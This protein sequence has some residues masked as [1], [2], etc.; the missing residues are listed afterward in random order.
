MGNRATLY[1][2]RIEI[3][4]VDRGIYEP[5]DVRT[6]LHPSETP[7]FLL[8]RVLAYVLNVPTSND[9]KIEFAPGGISDTDE[10]AIRMKSLDGRTTMWI[11]IGSPSTKKLHKG[12]KTADVVKVYAHKDPSA[13]VQEIKADGVHRASEIEVYLFSKDL[14]NG[15]EGAIER[16]NKWSL[17][18]T[19]GA[20]TV[21]IGD[22][23]FEGDVRRVIAEDI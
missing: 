15:L 18:R 17:I 11:E 3:S 14:L 4:D 8:T 1:R 20:L 23:V 5:V 10:P 19:D 7:R 16:D 2:F 21:T 13:L 22:Q 9:E 12:S 6:A